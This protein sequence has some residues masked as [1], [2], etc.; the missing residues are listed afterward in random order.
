M[1][2][3]TQANNFLGV[4][5]Y[6]Y[7][8]AREKFLKSARF[9]GCDIRSFQNDRCTGLQGEGLFCDV[10]TLGSSDAANKL[11]V[12]S[13]VHGVEGYCGSAMQKLLLDR[14]L[15][16]A[17]LE[18][19]QFIFVHALNPHGFS[20]GLRNTEDNVDLN[21]NFIDFPVSREIDKAELEFRQLVYPASWS[22][23]DL[24]EIYINIDKYIASFG[25]ERFQTLMSQ[26]QY[27]S[28]SAPYFGGGGPSWSNATW[29]IICAQYLTSA[30]R[31]VHMDIHTGLGD[32]GDCEL[33]YT[34]PCESQ[35]IEQA[36]G[37]FST[38]S[39]IAPGEEGSV[40]PAISG[41]LANGLRHYSPSAVCVALEFGTMP[42]MPV[43]K[44]MIA[45]T[46]L[47]S[48]PEANDVAKMAIRCQVR[49][50]FFIEGNEWMAQVWSQ[51]ETYF[52]NAVEYLKR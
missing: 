37:I 39:V 3:E 50:A 26:G 41:A 40:T 13:G 44:S 51:T 45:A 46:W 14:S 38:A 8:E 6:S 17:D 28:Q 10:A 7:T 2:T 48:N 21:R 35:S 47:Y 4:A 24:N 11:I 22:G 43:F 36:R 1:T 16:Q 30:R 32:S 25:F 18:N 34:G 31:V 29:S 20:H 49:D 52:H 5:S 42:V 33:I 9:L 12:S 15:K 27:A 23:S 19:T